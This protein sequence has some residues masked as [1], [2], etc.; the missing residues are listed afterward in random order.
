MSRYIISTLAISVL[1]AFFAQDT[2]S[3]ADIDRKKIVYEESYYVVKPE[4]KEKF[5]E[6]FKTRLIPFWNEMQK[7]GII[8]GE[9]KLFSQRLHTLKPHWTYKTR[10]RFKNY[11]AV[12]K[13]LEIKD[14]V[15]NK[16]FPGE[17]GYKGPRKQIDLITESHWDEFMREVDMGK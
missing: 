4:N 17:G 8:V 10:V 6:I 14:E 12:E 15:Y 16:L 3:A 2:Q 13:W 5:V 11:Q 1:C 9:Y 7:M